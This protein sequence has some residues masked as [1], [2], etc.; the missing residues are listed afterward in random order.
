M[1][2]DQFRNGLAQIVADLV[3]AVRA[4]ISLLTPDPTDRQWSAFV[5]S[6]Y[7]IVMA[8]RRRAFLLARDYY[9]AQRIDAGVFE[10][11]PELIEQ[12][13]PIQVLDQTLT[14]TTRA[15]LTGVEELELDRRVLEAE[16]LATL[17]RHGMAAGRDAVVDAARVDRAAIGYARVPSGAETCAFCTML[18]SRGPVYKT[19][20]KALHRDGSGEP[21]H[22]R[23]DCVVVA[24]FDRN[25]WPGREEFL[26]AE[27]QW[28][29]ATHG[30]SGNDALNALR[31]SLEPQ[32]A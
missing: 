2:P 23:C 29:T 21:Y 7:P 1:T 15:R 32:E 31:K 14:E 16:T 20:S 18:V 3:A 8:A 25:D 13:Y 19:R 27:Q 28:I 6:A 9:A 10:D 4:L 22:N 30:K 12:S 17:E 24:V 11:P 5:E 26:A